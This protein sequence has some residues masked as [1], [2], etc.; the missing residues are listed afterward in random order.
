M[1]IMASDDERE[2]EVG[3]RK[4][5]K[6][7]RF[8]K[9]TSGNPAGRPRGSKNINTL[10]SEEFQRRVA[11]REGGRPKEMT[12]LQAAVTQFVNK[13]V[14]GDPRFTPLLFRLAEKQESQAAVLGPVDVDGDEVIDPEVARQLQEAWKKIRESQK[15]T[16][17]ESQPATGDESQPASAKKRRATGES[18][19]H[20]T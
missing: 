17:G 13:L 2:Y 15:A 11:V 14:S 10:L 3:Y 1:K 7:T 19:G 20:H 6:Q 18:P 9:G 16:A 5:P 12:K 8:K 4:P